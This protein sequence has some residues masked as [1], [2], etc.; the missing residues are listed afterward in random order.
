MSSIGWKV[1]GAFELKRGP[2][3]VAC[4]QSEQAASETIPGCYLTHAF[5]SL[6]PASAQLRTYACC[7]R[8]SGERGCQR[9]FSTPLPPIGDPAKG[10]VSRVSVPHEPATNHCAGPANS[11]PAVDIDGLAGTQGIVDGV[12]DRGHLL[13]AARN[14]RIDDRMPL[15]L[16]SLAQS[17]S[18]LLSNF[19]VGE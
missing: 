9:T 13:R 15:P 14:A 12:K 8:V 11:A 16:N 10:F 6:C 19:E 2:Q 3:R 7:S 4:C 1:P 18:L 5:V 17:E